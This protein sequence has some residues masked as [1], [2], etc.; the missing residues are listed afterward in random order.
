MRIK[1]NEDQELLRDTVRRFADE[2]VR[3]RAKEI[4]ESG[5]FPRDFF[6]EAGGGP[7]GARP[8]AHRRV[9]EGSRGILVEHGVLH[10]LRNQA[11]GVQ[12]GR[13]VGRRIYY[14]ASDVAR[15]ILGGDK[16]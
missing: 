9:R 15:I 10:G 5:V 2:V 12:A 13:R 3:P 7:H 16:I 1:L 14:P 4:D 8:P 6:D 11:G